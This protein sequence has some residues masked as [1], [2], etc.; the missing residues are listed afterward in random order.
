MRPLSSNTG[1]MCLPLAP[2]RIFA[3]VDGPWLKSWQL[4]V[5]PLCQ[6]DHPAVLQ[7][8]PFGSLDLSSQGRAMPWLSSVHTNR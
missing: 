3:C 2:V 1:G 8:A 6:L 7:T 4:C 5:P